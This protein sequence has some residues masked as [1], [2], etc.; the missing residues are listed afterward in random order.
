MRGERG[1]PASGSNSASLSLS[2]SWGS[3]V[4]E[5]VGGGGESSSSRGLRGSEGGAVVASSEVEG[6][7]ALSSILTSSLMTQ[8]LRSSLHDIA[9]SAT[10]LFMPHLQSMPP[11]TMERFSGVV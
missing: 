10:H 3:S 8:S 2:S 7:A 11:A 1:R 6:T 5:R 9:T 4:G